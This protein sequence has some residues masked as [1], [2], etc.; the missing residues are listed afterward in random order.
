ML[1]QSAKLGLSI[2]T[3]HA[4]MIVVCLTAFYL[5]GCVTLGQDFDDSVVT[6][7]Q[8][9]IT[10]KQQVQQALGTPWRVGMENGLTT[11]TYG[12][13]HYGLGKSVQAKDLIIRFDQKGELKSYAFSTTDVESH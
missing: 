12:R 2:V 5:S 6:K 3:K 1:I 9:E 4:H 11:W 8:K 13:Y 10:T 7:L